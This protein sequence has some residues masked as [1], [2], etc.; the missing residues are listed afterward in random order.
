MKAGNLFVQ[1][2]MHRI[3]PQLYFIRASGR[4]CANSF[5]DL[6]LRE[7]EGNR[8]SIFDPRG[9]D[10]VYL[11]LRGPTPY[12]EPLWE[13]AMKRTLEEERVLIKFQRSMAQILQLPR[14]DRRLE[15]LQDDSLA[16]GYALL[17]IRCVPHRR[18]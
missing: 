12:K 15:E 3:D 5:S 16:I 1:V 17:R 11:D 10:W 9:R 14:P 6:F 4:S 18:R 7:L 8:A 2:G 13:F